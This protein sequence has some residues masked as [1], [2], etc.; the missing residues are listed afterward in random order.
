MIRF[1]SGGAVADVRTTHG[2]C[3]R[4]G[5]GSV[6][7]LR[8]QWRVVRAADGGEPAHPAVCGVPAGVRLLRDGADPDLRQLR[9][10][11]DP[12]PAAVRATVR[13]DRTPPGGPAR[14]PR[15]RP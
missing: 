9:G 13:P 12:L 14:A 5:G 3:Q 2:G 1:R 8:G 7:V 6:A 15:G 4:T 10:G 11:A